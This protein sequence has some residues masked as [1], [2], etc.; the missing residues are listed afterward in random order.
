MPELLRHEPVKRIGSSEIQDH[1]WM[2]EDD[3]SDE[4]RSGRN[5]RF[6]NPRSTSHVTRV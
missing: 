2:A 1:M 6:S 3:G 4:N 5:E